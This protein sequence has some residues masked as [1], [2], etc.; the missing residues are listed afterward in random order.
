MVRG[1]FSSGVF[2][3]GELSGGNEPGGGKFYTVD[4]FLFIKRQT[5]DNTSSDNEWQRVC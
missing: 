3:L 5:S 2:I 1:Q 4:G